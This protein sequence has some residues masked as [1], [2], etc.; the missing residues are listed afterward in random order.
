MIELHLR[1]I[2]CIDR[3]FAG[4]RLRRD[5]CWARYYLTRTASRNWSGRAAD[6]SKRYRRMSLV[7][8]SISR[9]D[10]VE[11]FLINRSASWRATRNRGSECGV[12]SIFERL[13][14]FSSS[15]SFPWR[16]FCSANFV[17]KFIM[18]YFSETLYANDRI[19][20]GKYKITRWISSTS[21]DN[22][23]IWIVKI[24]N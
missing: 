5:T 6:V 2:Q 15:S 18:V 7:R 9:L 17:E 8:D 11:Q 23:N 12:Y 20:F 16:K 19:N 14:I 1:S 21:I 10:I 4:C 13:A 3:H 22:I 24:I